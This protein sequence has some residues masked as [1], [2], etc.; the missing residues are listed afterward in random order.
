MHPIELLGDDWF[1]QE[2]ENDGDRGG[3]AGRLAVE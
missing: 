2:I 3:S 1:V